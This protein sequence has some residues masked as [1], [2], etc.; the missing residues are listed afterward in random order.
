MDAVAAIKLLLSAS[1]LLLVF[2]LGLQA[3]FADATSMLRNFLRSPHWLLRAMISMYVVVPAAAVALALSFEL[4]P[5]LRGGVGGGSR[6]DS[7][8]PARQTTQVRR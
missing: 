5:A 1:I 6:P 3:S 7:T 8:D 4:P 2:A